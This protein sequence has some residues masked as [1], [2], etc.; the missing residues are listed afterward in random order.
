MQCFFPPS[1]FIY[2]EFGAIM[3]TVGKLRR[4]GAQETM[5]HALISSLAEEGRNATR[6]GPTLCNHSFFLSSSLHLQRRQQQHHHHHQ[7][8]QQ[9]MIV[10]WGFCWCCHCGNN[11][12]SSH[13]ISMSLLWMST[14]WGI[15]PCS[16]PPLKRQSL[17][18]IPA[19]W[20]LN[21]QCDI[22]WLMKIPLSVGSE[23]SDAFLE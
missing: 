22:H 1:F 6:V 21:I 11:N 14:V 16:A 20:M 9:N 4:E 8:Q 2:F 10:N 23:G 17:I 3:S 5:R 12:T 18:G 19:I 13:M 7:Q 15:S